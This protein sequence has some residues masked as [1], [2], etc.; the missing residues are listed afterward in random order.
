MAK[1][2][3]EIYFA[4]PLRIEPIPAAAQPKG[5]FTLIYKGLKIQGDN[6][7]TTVQVEH[8]GEIDVTWV[9]ETG[10]PAHVDGPT[11]WASTDATVVTVQVSTGNSLI[12][13]WHTV[14]VGNAQIQATADADLGTGIKTVTSTM[15][16]TVIPGEAVAGTMTV[17]DL[18]PGTPSGA[19]GA[20]QPKKK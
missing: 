18:G 19:S 10:K 12:A 20:Q 8:I 14:A 16:F 11:T 5:I 4:N 7:A 2:G 1:L 3:L 17:K 9:D 13:N 15:D 6:M